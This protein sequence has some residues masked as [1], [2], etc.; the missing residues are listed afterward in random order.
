M[1]KLILIGRLTKDPDVRY[2]PQNLCVARYTL[3]VDRPVKK[4]DDKKTDFIPC[5]AIGTNG[6]FAEKYL[7]QGIKIAVEGRWQ[8]GSYTNKDGQKIYTND[9]YIERQE[10]AESKPQGQNQ[11]QSAR[12]AQAAPQ[13]TGW[14]NVPDNLEDESLP[15]N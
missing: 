4:G 11:N 15:F 13:D 2:T 6:T 5:V 7:K 1:N 10:F 8:A 3:A 14:M 9:C 12:T